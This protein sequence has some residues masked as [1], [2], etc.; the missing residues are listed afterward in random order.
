MDKQIVALSLQSGARIW[1]RKIKPIS[2]PIA[3]NNYIFLITSN[4]EL[5][6]LSAINGGVYWKTDLNSVYED[7]SYSWS[8]ISIYNNNIVLNS[9][10]GDVVFFSVIDGTI[11]SKNRVRA[12]SNAAPVINDD[13]LYLLDNRNKLHSYKILYLLIQ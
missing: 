7:G 8:D 11:L 6:A 10:A 5:I 9:G 4:K 12:F 13:L 3:I 1:Q 2:T